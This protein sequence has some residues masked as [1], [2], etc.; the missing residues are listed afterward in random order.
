MEDSSSIIN[1]P[2]GFGVIDED[3]TAIINAHKEVVGLTWELME[4]GNKFIEKAAAVGRLLI[5][6]KQELGHGNFLPWLAKNIQEF[7]YQTA[8]DYM[9]AARYLGSSLNLPTDQPVTLRYIRDLRQAVG[10]LEDKPASSSEKGDKPP[11]VIRC[12]F[13][14]EPEK[15]DEL[16]R[17]TAFDQARPLLEAFQAFGFIEI[18]A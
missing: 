1:T 15:L 13:N 17:R 10:L 14:V 16:Q 4:T 2:S 12:A 3:V 5:A 18:K 11:F 7:G 9:K 8:H 6:K